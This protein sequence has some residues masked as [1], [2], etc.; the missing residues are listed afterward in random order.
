MYRFLNI[1]LECLLVLMKVVWLMNEEG[2][3]LYNMCRTI[4]L[5]RNIYYFYSLVIII[6]NFLYIKWM[7]H[8]L[9]SPLRCLEK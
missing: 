9:R 6:I 4:Y 3:E 8:I 5:I 7:R 2:K 1:L